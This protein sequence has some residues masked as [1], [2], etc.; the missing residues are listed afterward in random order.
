[1]N[2]R[3]CAQDVLRCSVC[4]EDPLHSYCQ[5]CHINLCTN[6]IES[7][8]SD[9][10]KHH[11]VVP[12]QTKNNNYP[13]CPQHR[14]RHCEDFCE[15]CDVPVCSNCLSS[16]K[17]NRHTLSDVLQKLRE[18]TE[19]LKNDLKELQDR[20]RPKYEE[21]VTDLRTQE[22]SLDTYCAELTAAIVREG[23]DWHRKIDIV[24]N[25]RLS[26][27]EE[28]KNKY[29][30]ALSKHEKDV[31]DTAS[32]IE[33]SILDL[34]KMLDSNDAF[35]IS[36]YESRN[37]EFRSFPPRVLVTVPIFTSPRDN[38][39]QL[40]QLFGS[41]S[42]SDVKTDENGY[43]M[44]EPEIPTSPPFKP[45]L[46]QPRTTVC[47]N[48]GQTWP[49]SVACLGDDKVW[50]CGYD[51]SIRLYNLQNRLLKS[52]QTKSGKIP[53]DIALMRSGE[54][55]YT[56]PQARGIN[57]V[58]NKKIKEM[59]RFKG[60]M[61]FNVCSTFSDDLLVSMCSVDY[62]ESKVV[63]FS[64]FTE[65]Q[66][67]QF[68]NDGTPLYSPGFGK[69]ITENRNLDICVSDGN[70]MAVVVVSRAG[71]LR[72]RYTGHPS[73]ATGPFTPRG[74]AADGQSQILVADIN[75]HCVYVLDSDG[76]LL[77]K[78]CQ[79]TSP[80]GIC[81][82]SRDNLYVIEWNQ[83]SMGMVRKIQYM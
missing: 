2:T 82:D 57:K 78:M 72:F 27:A 13:P 70:A 24:V 75:N 8:L 64:D 59:V 25:K 18:K 37:T 34:E 30:T 51:N 61:P 54:L 63:R 32:E 81:V 62:S 52:L 29:H 50:T 10:N 20:I 36:V 15:K 6:C 7:H 42:G 38:K 41:L 67:V 76:A 26:E 49:N 23:E 77:R 35:L 19:D 14:D 73:S 16:G 12:Y 21:I 80:Y 28:M 39:E 5:L 22:A 56:D 83:P 71:K 48:I 74:I 3:Y 65:T 45:L 1:M 66:T 11:P 47:I 33:Q 46:N 43:T 4:K 58:K 68:N 69:Y 55:V 79:I 17:H 31:R 60:W 40:D 9:S 53:G 44:E